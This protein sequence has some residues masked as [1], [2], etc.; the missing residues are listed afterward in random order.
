MA[1]RRGCGSLHRTA[2]ARTIRSADSTAQRAPGRL[3]RTCSTL[4]Q[5]PSTTPLPTG[6]PRRGRRR[7]ASGGRWRRSRRW[8]GPPPA[9]APWCGGGALR[10]G[11]RPG[12]G[13][14]EG[15]RVHVGGRRGQ[16][17]L[18]GDGLQPGPGRGRPLA[19]E[20]LGQGPQVRAGVVP[21]HDLHRAGEAPGGELPDPLRAVPQHHHAAGP[22]QA[23]ALGRGVELAAEGLG[24]GQGGR[25]GR[26]ARDQ[27]GG[28]PLTGRPRCGAPPGRRRRPA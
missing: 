14:G 13:G 20:E 10:R 27:R 26:G 9:G 2:R 17:Q 3:S 18:A 12:L 25:V 19:V 24:R 16:P 21:V 28:R 15:D 4:W 7:S 6:R 1:S 8:L 22:A 5:P 11:G 23:P